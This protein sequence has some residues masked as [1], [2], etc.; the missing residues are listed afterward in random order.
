MKSL[1]L[2]AALPFRFCPPHEL[3]QLYAGPFLL[4]VLG[5]FQ[6][7]EAAFVVPQIHAFGRGWFTISPN[8]RM[9]LVSV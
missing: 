1:L 7:L 8:Q 2:D 3:G 9:L 6:S 4:A 5:L